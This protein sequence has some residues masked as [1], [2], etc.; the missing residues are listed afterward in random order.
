[1][2]FIYHS[3]KS[4]LV[5]RGIVLQAPVYGWCIH[6]RLVGQSG[7]I[8]QASATTGDFIFS[9]EGPC[10]STLS[11]ASCPFW[12]RDLD[13]KVVRPHRRGQQTLGKG[14]VWAQRDRDEFLELVVTLGVGRGFQS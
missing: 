6:I 12:H 2:S 8:R 9:K 7:A 10:G 1:M 3:G 4:N 5:R 13:E 11:F 14:V